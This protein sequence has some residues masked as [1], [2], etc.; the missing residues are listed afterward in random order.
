MTKRFCVISSFLFLALAHYALADDISVTATKTSDLNFGT[1]VPLY[2]S[3]ATIG[4]RAGDG[5]PIWMRATKA[6]G[7]DNPTFGQVSFSRAGTGDFV[8]IVP[9]LATTSIDMPSSGGSCSLKVENMTLS[10]SVIMLSETKS[11]DEVNIGGSAKIS[12]YC[13]APHTYTHTTN[14][15]L[16][17]DVYDSGDKFLS[18]SSVNVPVKFRLEYKTEVETN[19]DM[20]FGT[21]LTDGTAGTVTLGV[22]NSVLVSNEH[23]RSLGGSPTAGEVSIYGIKGLN[24]TVEY[25]QNG[26]EILLY[27]GSHTVSVSN[28]TFSP[29]TSFTLQKPDGKDM[30]TEK[31]KIG[32]TLTIGENQPTGVYTGTL[33][34]RVSY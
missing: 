22:D 33:E 5:E 6:S 25:P 7:S 4:I 29:G 24:I 13:T 27:N 3:S 17:Y 26:T 2:A 10:K 16:E 31:L 32:G 19:N 12:G 9:T 1:A 14:V 21:I 20:N 8:K 28:F 34:V 30:F 15:A 23:L 11:S 18:H